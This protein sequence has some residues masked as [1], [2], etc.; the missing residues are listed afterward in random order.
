MA[1]NKRIVVVGIPGVGKTSLLAKMLEIL[2]SKD[3]S[4][5]VISFGTTMFD[6][7]KENG[8]EDRDQL[9]SLPISEQKDL[10]KA[11]ASR[12]AGR[13]EQI[14]IID[15]H[16]FVRSPEGYYPGL[17]AHVLEIIRPT[18]FVSV[19]ARPE[20]IFSRRVSDVTRKRD[21]VNIL[22]IKKELAVQSGMMSACSVI[23]GSPIKQ[24]LN[25]E[26]RID[27]AADKIIRSMEL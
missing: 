9:R 8:V 1:E 10:Q 5:T 21:K 19:T 22:D 12:I 6:I 26:G 27:E 17:P 25:G 4:V 15:T 3:R 20:E 23:T 11:A 14:V 24:I 16:A 2:G 13:S 7:A 18:N